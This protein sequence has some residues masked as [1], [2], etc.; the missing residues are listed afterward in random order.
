MEKLTL[1]EL[2]ALESLLE[3]AAQDEDFVD[4]VFEIDEVLVETSRLIMK[5]P[6]E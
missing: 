4:V 1:D 3:K 5:A 6:E 2:E